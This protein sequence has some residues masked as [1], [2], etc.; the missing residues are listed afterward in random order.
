MS[1]R[2]I[3]VAL[4]LTG[5]IAVL[6][7]WFILYPGELSVFALIKTAL[8]I[9]LSYIAMIFDIKSKRIPN[10]LVL[11][12]IAGWIVLIAF[13]LS[14]NTES[15]V[16]LLIDSTFG[17]LTGGGMFLLV[18]LM[19]RKGLGGGDVKFIAAAGLYLGLAN[20]INTILFGSILAAITG[21]TLILLK[22]I[23]R[24]DT[25]PLAP[26]MFMGIMITVFI[27]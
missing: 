2:E 12:M 21:L 15:G 7:V 10:K 9:I 18:Y 25:I 8:L 13:A 23:K 26:F 5:L 11:L 16:K 3:R 6:A 22:K 4:Y 1:I 20:T 27:T 19:S 17:L 14:F 24:K